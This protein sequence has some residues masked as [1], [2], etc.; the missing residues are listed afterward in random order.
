MAESLSGIPGTISDQAKGIR[1]HR[2]PDHAGCVRYRADVTD[3]FLMAMVSQDPVGAGGRP[4]WHISVSHRDVNSQPDRCPNWDELK[5]AA[6]RLVPA[7]VPLV[8]VFPR[9]STPLELYVNIA[10]YCL[11][12]WESEDSNI[13]R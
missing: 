1:W 7:D 11:H 9:R 3:G 13:D 6:Y 12:L 5:H 10:E 4:L 8:L 2:V